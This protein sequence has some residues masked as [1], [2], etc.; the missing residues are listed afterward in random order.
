MS[1]TDSFDTLER[2]VAAMHMAASDATAEVER[3]PRLHGDE[4]GPVD[5]FAPRVSVEKMHPRFRL[6]ESGR[7]HNAAREIISSLMRC[8]DD[9]DGNFVEQFQSTGFDARIWELYLYA[10]LIEAGYSVSFPDQ[11]PDLL[12]IGREHRFG[13][14]ATTIN[15]SII[16]GQ[17][18]DAPR[19]KTP[20][21]V[22]DYFANY[23]PIRFAGPLTGVS[24]KRWIW[25]GGH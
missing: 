5:F 8:Y 16:N 6:I 1:H 13:I 11:A 22:D 18:V 17:T 19:P 24:D 12:A 15:P 4:T 25:R 3:T 7:G 23:L 20:Q 9:R 10:L 14:E 2:A 21:E